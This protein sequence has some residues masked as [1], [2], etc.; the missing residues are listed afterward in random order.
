MVGGV[1]EGV[2]DVVGFEGEAWGGVVAVAVY[3]LLCFFG[4]K[5]R[6]MT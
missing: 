2:D 4:A 1:G 6:V 5:S 3:V